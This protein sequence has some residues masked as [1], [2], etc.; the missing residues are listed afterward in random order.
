MHAA[1]QVVLPHVTAPAQLLPPLQQS[2]LFDAA[3]V[4]L[5]P[6]AEKSA[7]FT[8]QVDVALHV[9]SPWQALL[10]QVT[11]HDGPPP[12]PTVPPHAANALQSTS[13]LVA[14][15]HA[16][17]PPHELDAQPIQ[18]VSPVQVV[19]APHALLVPASS[20]QSTTQ[21]FAVQVTSPVHET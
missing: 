13:Q 12:H 15:V 14:P 10:P 7:Q 5:P 11:S 16:T 18:Q 21:L 9:T 2:V 1:L 4:T 8:R 20:P 6:H 19:F 3:L 17:L